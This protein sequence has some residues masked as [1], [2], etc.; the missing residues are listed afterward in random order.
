MRRYAIAT[1]AAF[2]ALVVA[3]RSV[4]AGS[5]LTG[6]ILVPIFWTGLLYSVLGVWDPVMQTRIPWLW[7]MVAQI[8]FGMVAGYVVSRHIPIST[9]QH[10]PFAIRAGIEAEM[11]DD[12]GEK[13]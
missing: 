8:I 6:G 7:F 12:E 4:L 3:A 11:D 13:T 2:P 1:V 9:L 10:V 5:I